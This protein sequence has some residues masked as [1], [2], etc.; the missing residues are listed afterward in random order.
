MMLAPRLDAPAAKAKFDAGDAIP[1]DVTS[2]LVYPAVSR[3]IP[4]SIRVAPEPIIRAL[5]AL[6]P[7][8]EILQYLSS[9][10]QDRPVVAYCT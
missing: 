6:R 1:L 7:A 4:G 8:S 2:S 9:V 5:Q 10:P 3:R